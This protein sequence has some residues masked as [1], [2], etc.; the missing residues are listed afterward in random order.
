LGD[1]YITSNCSLYEPLSDL[2]VLSVC[3]VGVLWPNGWVDQR[4]YT[5]VQASGDIVLDGNSAPPTK[6]AQQP[7]FS[8]HVYCGETVVHFSWWWALVYDYASKW[9]SYNSKVV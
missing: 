6:R 2:T 1:C 3:N 9:L 4:G 7:H 5:A 8:A